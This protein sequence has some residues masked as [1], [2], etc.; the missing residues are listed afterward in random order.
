L[1]GD[2][3]FYC[4]DNLPI[5]RSSAPS[6]DT[7]VELGNDESCEEEAAESVASLSA[8]ENDEVDVASPN[9]RPATSDAIP[10][11]PL[12]EVPLLQQVLRRMWRRRQLKKRLQA[13]WAKPR[14]DPISESEERPPG[15]AYSSMSPRQ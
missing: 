9:E 1:P 8:E 7:D 13:L 10:G 4:E 11:I 15:P 6:P 3:S 12:A 2:S 5:D 14:L